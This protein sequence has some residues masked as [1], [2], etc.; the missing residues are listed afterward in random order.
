MLCKK[1][2]TLVMQNSCNFSKMLVKVFHKLRL[3][4][5]WNKQ[6]VCRKSEDPPNGEISG[7]REF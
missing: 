6:R 2:K 1:T 5:S 3:E 7:K 4:D